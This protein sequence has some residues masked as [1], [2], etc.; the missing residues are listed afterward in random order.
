[1]YSISTL[2]EIKKT[3]SDYFK[4]KKNTNIEKLNNSTT[5]Y[6]GN[7]SFYTSESKIYQHFS[8]CGNVKRV[9]MGLNRN[10]KFPCGFC[11]VEFYIRQD[12][13]N[14][15][16]SLNLFQI[17]NRSIRVD[18]DIGFEEGR[19]YGRGYTGGQKRDEFSKR[20]DPDRPK[21]SFSNNKN[22]N[23]NNNN[24]NNYRRNNYYN[25]YDDKNK[26][27][28]YKHSNKQKDYSYLNKKKHL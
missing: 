27:N 5:L 9:I 22:E 10:T 16:N 21:S 28:D 11:F 6:V 2:Y 7:L 15:I 23:N 12:A 25:K 24:N 14:A 1:M 19:Q 20:F 8:M 4:E 13:E 26:D 18:W 3:N 17:D